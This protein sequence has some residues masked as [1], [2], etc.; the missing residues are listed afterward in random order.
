MRNAHSNV[1]CSIAVPFFT[2]PYCKAEKLFTHQVALFL[3]GIQLEA[4]GIFQQ[5]L[6]TGQAGVVIGVA[7]LVEIDCRRL[8]AHVG[9]AVALRRVKTGRRGAIIARQPG[10]FCPARV[11]QEG[12]RVLLCIRE[13]P[14]IPIG[15]DASDCSLIGVHQRAPHV[16]VVAFGCDASVISLGPRAETAGKQRVPLPKRLEDVQ[17]HGCNA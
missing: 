15:Q 16:H 10:P 13:S 7:G 14:F 17:V 8:R 3:A 12:F 5:F 1:T 9:H 4:D 6:G 2:P 11:R